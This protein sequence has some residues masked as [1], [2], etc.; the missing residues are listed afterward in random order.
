[1]PA[2]NCVSK[3]FHWGMGFIILGLLVAGFYMVGLA[4]SP[5]KF[6][7][8]GYH[9]SFGMLVFGLGVIRVVWSLVSQKP[10]TLKSHAVW[11]VFLA[12]TIHVVFYISFLGVPLS[13][14]FM[15][16]AGEFSNNFFGLFDFPLLI[17][18]DEQ[19]F[20]QMKT[21][22]EAFSYLLIVSLALHI[23][24]AVKHH[25]IDRDQTLNRMGNLFLA[26]IG[27]VL[28]LLV[29][30]A[31]VAHISFRYFVASK[32][33]HSDQYVGEVFENSVS[34][35]E[36]GESVQK[37]IIDPKRSAI[38][39]AFMQYGQKV[40]G[41][42]DKWIGDIFFDPNDLEGSTARIL[43]DTNSI[44]T[45]TADR[46]SQA[47]DADWFLVAEYPYAVFQSESFHHIGANRY[48]VSGVLTLRG[49]VLPLSFPFLLEFFEKTGGIK[50]AVVQ[51]NL[52]LNRLDFGIGQGQWQT[53]EAIEDA[54]NVHINVYAGSFNCSNDS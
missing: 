51:A 12:K 33:V 11:E 8:Y 21:V 30:V 39:F 7:V 45:G 25:F 34:R 35:C 23:A 4:F 32:T 26:S 15:S 43:I 48:E 54:V 41:S 14:W 36:Q 44:K 13:G 38:K 6:S 37:W 10:E 24:G 1:M 50:Q 2:Y 19:V 28:F 42:F 49:V 5:F 27:I 16:S 31:A 40:S 20:E 46:D 47:R 52:S 29:F 22:H 9:K 3:C 18:K 53:T 17:G